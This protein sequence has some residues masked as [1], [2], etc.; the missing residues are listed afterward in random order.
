[1]TE[2]EKKRLKDLSNE[3][4]KWRALYVWQQG[5]LAG[6]LRNPDTSPSQLLATMQRD[7]RNQMIMLGLDG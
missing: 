7:M 6:L 4:T 2:E 3:L 1:M 5:Y